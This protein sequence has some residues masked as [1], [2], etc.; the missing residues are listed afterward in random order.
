MQHD[1][2]SRI[3][4]VL[5]LLELLHEVGDLP[6]RDIVARLG[7]DR[8]KVIRDIRT[9]QQAGVPIY[10]VGK[11]R[12]RRHCLA[13]YYR[14]PPAIGD[15]PLA[16][17]VGRA[18]V[19][20][21]SFRWSEAQ[22]LPLRA[23]GVGGASERSRVDT[24]LSAVV[25]RNRCTFQ[26]DPAS[27][28]AHVQPIGL[29]CAE[30]RLVVVSEDVDTKRHSAW[31]ADRLLF[32]VLEPSRDRVAEP[33]VAQAFVNALGCGGSPLDVHLTTISFGAA[34]GVIAR[35]WAWPSDALWATMPSKRV[36]VTCRLT[37]EQVLDRVLRLAPDAIVEAPQ[38]LQAAGRLSQTG[39]TQ[40]K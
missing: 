20:G 23:I 25:H 4:R 36:S 10:A 8:K 28:P 38:H 37:P 16:V 7:M 5:R 34:T 30:G 9:L 26:V 27:P 15:E 19:Y 6:T 1:G 39:T 12:N 31:L 21:P 35:R 18:V 17:A 2:E 40:I 33:D 11:G 24:L 3:S 14:R 13:H 32:D 29:L 22:T